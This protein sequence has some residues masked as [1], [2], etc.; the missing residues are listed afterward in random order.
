M[1]EQSKKIINPAAGAI[2]MALGIFL[3]GALRVFSDHGE[4]FAFVYLIISLLIFTM[5]IRQ[6]FQ[7]DFWRLFLR[8]PVNSFVFG[9]WIAGLSVLCQVLIEYFPSLRNF[10]LVGTIGA[11]ILW[12]FFLIICV[13]NFKQLWQRPNFHATH[14]VV[15]LSTVATQAIVILWAGVLPVLPGFLALGTLILGIFFYL[16]GLA[17]IVIRYKRGKWSLDEDW[18]NTNCIIHGALSITGLAIVS[19]NMFSATFVLG[20]WLMVV[21]VM[22]MIETVELWRGF[23]RVKKRG[24]IQGVFT[25]HI[26]QWSRNFTFGMFYAFTMVMLDIPKYTTSFIEVQ[27][28]VLISWAWVV[29][30]ALIIEIAL[31]G[32]ASFTRSERLD[33]HPES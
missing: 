29:M 18:A 4:I 26:S 12:I 10:V 14:G 2:V 22:V 15:L 19:V 13:H 6:S 23:V 1:L 27:K 16:N 17:L 31:W 25:Y 28:V 8:N 24:W 11:T 7:K 21:L 3:F 30:F 32:R 33:M 9:S 5:L 20:Y